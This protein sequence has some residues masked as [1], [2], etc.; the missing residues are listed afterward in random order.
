MDTNSEILSIIELSDISTRMS[1]QRHGYCGYVIKRFRLISAMSH[2]EMMNMVM[3]CS[4]KTIDLQLSHHGR[5]D[6]LIRTDVILNKSEIVA[7]S[8][9]KFRNAGWVALNKIL[10]SLLDAK[11]IMVITNLNS[12]LQD[13]YRSIDARRWFETMTKVE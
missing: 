11:G 8:I 2:Q 9:D 13:H 6:L 10:E 4:D 12:D 3:Q 7:L 1:F 5:V